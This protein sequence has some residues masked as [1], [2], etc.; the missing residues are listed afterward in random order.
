MISVISLVLRQLS[1]HAEMTMQARLCSDPT[2]PGECVTTVNANRHT[3][4]R[5]PDVSLYKVPL[6]S[7][8]TL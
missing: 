5:R 3:G 4:R 8:S 6:T 7:P 1:N 2:Q